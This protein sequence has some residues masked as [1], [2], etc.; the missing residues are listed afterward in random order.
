MAQLN[1]GST[2]A[3]N[4]IIHEGNIEEKGIAKQADVDDINTTIGTATL[5]TTDQTIKG[6]INE[7][8]E[9]TTS[10]GSVASYYL[11][12]TNLS[13]KP[14]SMPANGGNSDTVDGKHA[15]DFAPSGYGLG[16]IGK[17]L[18]SGID[19][20]TVINNGWYD[21]NNSTNLPS[22]IGTGYAKLLVICSADINYIT[23]LAFSMTTGTVGTMYIREKRVNTWGSWIR[24]AN[25]NDIA[26]TNLLN[27]PTTLSGYGITDGALK[28]DVQDSVQNSSTQPTNQMKGGIWLA[29]I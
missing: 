28:T 6:A 9:S 16:G 22:D 5:G 4:E 10:G 11:D 14:T 20:N 13:N 24:I 15:A 7:I 18:G 25:M 12:Y 29:P 8:K 19:A 3:G 23:Q 1:G 2:V 26:F 21:I 27:K 17:R